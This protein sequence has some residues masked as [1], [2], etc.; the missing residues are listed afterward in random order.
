MPTTPPTATAADIAN[1][2]RLALELADALVSIVETR[3]QRKVDELYSLAEVARRLG[4]SRASI[5]RAVA[6]GDLATLTVGRR[7]LVS[8]SQLAAFIVRRAELGA[9][10]EHAR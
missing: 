10:G 5:T 7:R 6:R 4:L 2:R 3:A 8:E 1:V 9:V